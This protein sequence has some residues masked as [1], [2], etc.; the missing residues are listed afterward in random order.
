VSRIFWVLL[1]GCAV[2]LGAVWYAGRSKSR[3]VDSGQ[4]FVHEQPAAKA[5]DADAAADRTAQPAQVPEPAS[6]ASASG[7]LADAGDAM[8]P[9]ADTIRRDPP[10][11]MAFAG[12]G[13][14]QLYRQ[15]DITWRL[16][17]ETGAACIL[18]ATDAEWRKA[19]VFD[20]GCG[21]R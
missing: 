2:I 10:N 6:N 18:F 16:N 17:T 13:K 11:G 20:Q 19:R 21:G 7:S 8:P 3:A 9:A 15:G 5:A 4:V 1:S 12:K 14:Y